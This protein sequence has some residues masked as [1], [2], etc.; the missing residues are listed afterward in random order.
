MTWTS[1][2]EEIMMWRYLEDIYIYIFHCINLMK[3]YIQN[4]TNPI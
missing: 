3:I 1:M 4:K 2:G